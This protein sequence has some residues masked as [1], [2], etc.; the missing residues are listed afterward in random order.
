MK[1]LLINLLL[2]VTMLI[3]TPLTSAE[4][5]PIWNKTIEEGSIQDMQLMKGG[6]EF[7]L[8]TGFWDKGQLQVRNTT[9]GEL[10]RSQPINADH[11]GKIIITPDSN[12]FIVLNGLQ[13]ELRNLDDT[14]SIVNSFNLDV[15]YTN[16]AIE[17]I[18]PYVYVT[19]VKMLGYY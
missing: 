7:L 9:D 4:V 14:F 17:P 6:D 19:E 5:I 12:R 13:C 15:I 8:F 2:A 11:N 1:N 10:I 18:I 3:A 16:I